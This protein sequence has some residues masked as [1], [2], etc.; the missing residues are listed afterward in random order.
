MKVSRLD[1]IDQNRSLVFGFVP[2]IQTGDALDLIGQRAGDRI[3]VV[4]DNPPNPVE[5]TTVTFRLNAVM[6]VSD[7]ADLE[8]VNNLL[9]ATVNGTIGALGTGLAGAM[10]A[11]DGL[12]DATVDTLG[13]IMSTPGNQGNI[14]ILV[15]VTDI[16]PPAP[17]AE[18]LKIS[19]SG[20]VEGWTRTTDT[21]S[22]EVATISHKAKILT[23]IGTAITTKNI[24][25]SSQIP[26]DAT[27]SEAISPVSTTEVQAV[28]EIGWKLLTDGAITH[29]TISLIQISTIT[30]VIKYV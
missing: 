22:D 4:P 29:D 28:L 18:P 8:D 23:A 12:A 10:K 9:H 15:R 6:A 21:D 2:D 19:V 25:K 14:T 30:L 7:G 17:P 26:I 24:G 13:K 11:A 20:S 27:M 3:V 1:V 16:K 5:E